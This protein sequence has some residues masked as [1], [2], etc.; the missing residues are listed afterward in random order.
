MAYP[1]VALVGGKQHVFQ[2]MD[3]IFH[4]LAGS[5]HPGGLYNTIGISPPPPPP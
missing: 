3:T 2:K 1:A 5:A 4:W